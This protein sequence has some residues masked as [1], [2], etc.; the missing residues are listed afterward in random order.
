MALFLLI[1]LVAVVAGIVGV[2]VEGMMWLLVAA[3]VV[4][5]LDLVFLGARLRGGRKPAR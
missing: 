4:T 2:V 1:L 5:L 3:I